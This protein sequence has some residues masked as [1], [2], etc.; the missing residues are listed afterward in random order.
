MYR[1]RV[2]YDEKRNRESGRMEGREGGRGGATIAGKQS[3]KIFASCLSLFDLVWKYGRSFG[4][5]LLNGKTVCT[6]LRFPVVFHLHLTRC[7]FGS[8]IGRRNLACLCKDPL[9]ATWNVHVPF[10][11][12]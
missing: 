12:M 1:R 4:L 6:S 10:D 5:R 2:I 9:R 8:R 3:V 11:G 7:K